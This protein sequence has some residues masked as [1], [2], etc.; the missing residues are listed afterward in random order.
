MRKALKAAQLS[1]RDVDYINAHGTGTKSGDLTEV[2]GIEKCFGSIAADIPVSSIKGAIGHTLGASGA[3]EA[4]VCLLALRDQKV[5]PTVNFSEPDPEREKQTVLM[6]HH[7][8]C[9]ICQ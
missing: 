5:P 6:S 4:V 2:L 8:T 9:R 3:I 7:F 1:I